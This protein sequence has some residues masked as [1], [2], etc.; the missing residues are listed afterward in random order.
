MSRYSKRP[1]ADE[2]PFLFSA[3]HTSKMNNSGKQNDHPPMHRHISSPFPGGLHQQPPPK[4]SASSKSSGK[5]IAL[6]PGEPG[7]GKDAGETTWSPKESRRSCNWLLWPR[8]PPA[9]RRLIR[10]RSSTVATS[11]RAI[12]CMRLTSSEEDMRFEFVEDDHMGHE[13]AGDVHHHH[14][15]S[16]DGKSDARSDR[17]SHLERN[18]RAAMSKPT[19][20]VKTRGWI[21]LWFLITIPVIFWDA[22][23]CFMRPHSFEGGPW[24]ALWKPYSIYQNVDLVYGVQ[25]YLDKNGFTNAQSLLNIIENFLNITY[26]YLVHG[27]SHGPRPAAPLLGL[28]SAATTLAKTVLYWAQEYYCDYCAVGHNSG[29][30]LLVY[31][32]IPN[33]LWIVVPSMIVYTLWNDILSDLTV[34]SRLTPAERRSAILKAKTA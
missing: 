18:P 3:A 26:I 9:L 7:D 8:K 1:L 5:L 31:W 16:K 10:T 2:Y 34:A 24:H 22:G 25:Q 6:E 30:D 15:L 19:S 29:K 12:E 23:Y 17:S 11:T 21:S 28:V 33:G 20:N 4:E 14:T 32:I 27:T 13:R